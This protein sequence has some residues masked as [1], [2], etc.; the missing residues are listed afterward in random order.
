MK[1]ITSYIEA[2]ENNKHTLLAPLTETQIEQLKTSIQVLEA[3]EMQ[4]SF[5]LDFQFIKISC[6]G[7]IAGLM[8]I[9]RQ[10]NKKQNVTLS[11]CSLLT[12]PWNIISPKQLHDRRFTHLIPRFGIGSLLIN[13]AIRLAKQESIRKIELISLSKHSTNFY[14]KHYFEAEA[15]T[16]EE[17]AMKLDLF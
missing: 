10:S 13:E 7:Q 15:S 17:V 12:A 1:D 8:S 6:N 11:I 14:L 5:P 2:I 16:N 4:L 9:Q 3:I